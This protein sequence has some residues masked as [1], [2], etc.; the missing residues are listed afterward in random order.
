MRGTF[1]RL[2][3]R[4]GAPRGLFFRNPVLRA[5][6]DGAFVACG[7]W[8]AE[9]LADGGGPLPL[10]RAWFEQLL[11]CCNDVGLM[12]EEMDPDTLDAI[13]NFPQ[14]YSHVGL[15]SAALAL[16]Q[17]ARRERTRNARDT[18][19]IHDADAVLDSHHSPGLLGEEAA[20]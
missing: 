12:S 19:D 7:F 9:L 13:G 5:Q 3:E 4:L 8:G 1:R 20:P 18:Q 2:V 11:H 16:D 15:I 14:A 17:R 6:G 10:A